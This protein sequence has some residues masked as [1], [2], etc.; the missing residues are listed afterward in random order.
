MSPLQYDELLPE[1]EI[2]QDEIPAGVK[3][4]CERAEPTQKYPEHGWEL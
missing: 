1:N 4:A 3:Q 2:L